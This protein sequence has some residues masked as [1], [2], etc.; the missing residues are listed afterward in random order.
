MT[1]RHQWSRETKVDDVEGMRQP[2]KKCT[3]CG[4][5]RTPDRN[6][7]TLSLFRAAGTREWK[8][9]RAGYVPD[10]VPVEVES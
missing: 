2:V 6:T 1:T 4:M 3:A 8:G 5:R 10:C 9:Y 7:K